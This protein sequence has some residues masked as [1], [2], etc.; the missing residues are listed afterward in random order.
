MKTFVSLFKKPAFLI[1][2]LVSTF[3]A[4][5][6]IIIALFMG[7]EAGNFVIQV[8]SGDVRKSVK[9]TEN[10]SEAPTSRLEAPSISSVTNTTYDWFSGKLSTYHMTDGITI[11]EELHI[12]AYSFYLLND[13]EESLEVKSTMYYSN[14]SNNLDKGI[15]VMTLSSKQNQEDFQVNGCYQAKDEKE[16]DEPYGSSYPAMTEFVSDDTVFEE[17]FLSFDPSTHIKYTILI[18]I[19][20]K[21][22]DTTNELWN[23]TIRFTLKLSIL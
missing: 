8:E 3:L 22:P 20:G 7:Q 18:W 23:G 4:C 6:I 2:M 17:S 10:L 12:Y 19:E 11:D 16:P 9:L 13:S 14:V 21:D 15:R 5:A 1:G